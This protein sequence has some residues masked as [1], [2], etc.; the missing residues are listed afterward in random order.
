MT[1]MTHIQLSLLLDFLLMHHGDT[2]NHFKVVSA[3]RTISNRD[4]QKNAAHCN[5]IHILWTVNMWRLKL[6][7]R[8]NTIW[9]TGHFVCPWCKPLWC[10]RE[11]WRANFFPQ[12]LQTNLRASAGAVRTDE[13]LDQSW[14]S[15]T[16]QL[17][18]KGRKI[19]QC[20]YTSEH[21]L[22]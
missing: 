2:G 9:H 10:V 21:K 5:F 17:A 22:N 4:F 19:L 14:M 18:T 11:S 1:L 20:K 16:A 3:Y 12:S 15:R 13:R 8:L 6:N 7:T